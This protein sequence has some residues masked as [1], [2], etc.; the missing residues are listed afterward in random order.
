M[1][2]TKY[3][4]DVDGFDDAWLEMYDSHAVDVKKKG[5]TVIENVIITQDENELKT[6]FEKKYE[7]RLIQRGNG[8]HF[9]YN[10]D[11]IQFP[12]ESA[13]TMFVLTWA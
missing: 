3:T 5:G 1:V 8:H 9:W 13:Y 2:I 10:F 12:T 6:T 11:T 4:V 7:C